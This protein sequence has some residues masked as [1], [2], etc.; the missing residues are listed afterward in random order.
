MISLRVIETIYFVTGTHFTYDLIQIRWKFH[1]TV[2]QLPVVIILQHNFARATTVQLPCHV[3]NF[4]VI[5]VP[6]LGWEQK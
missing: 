1:L 4:V 3:Q 6:K 2:I 5:T